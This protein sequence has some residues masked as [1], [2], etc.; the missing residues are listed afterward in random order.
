MMFNHKTVL[1]LAVAV[2]AALVPSAF[3]ADHDQGSV[4]NAG[5]I[6][7]INLDA[8]ELVAAL[9]GD[10]VT[11]SNAIFKGGSS[12]GATFTDS[13]TGESSVFG[14]REG[15][16]LSTGNV[17]NTMGP[18]NNDGE[19]GEKA[20]T[21]GDSDLDDEFFKGVNE[22]RDATVLEFD[23]VC[24]DPIGFS[25]QYVFGS[26]EYNEFVGS[27]FNDV[28]AVFLNGKNIALLPDNRTVSINNINCG[29]YDIDPERNTFDTKR[30][31]N[32]CQELFVDNTDGAGLKK[33]DTQFDGF[34][35]AIYTNQ[36]PESGVNRLK[37]VVAD[38]R[39]FAIDSAVLLRRN[40]LV[41][42]PPPAP[43]GNGGA[44]GDPHF[45]T[46]RG[47]HYDYHGECDLV[48]IHNAEFESGLGLDVHIRTKLRRDMSYISS[49][50]LRI[51][52]DVL[53][54]ASQGVYWFN[55][56][57]KADL[58]DEFAGFA[59]LHTHPTDKQHLF[60]VYLGDREHIKIK[61]YQDF[62]SVLIEQ[63]NSGHFLHSVGLMG[64]FR[65]GHMIARDGTTV[66]DDANAFG[67]EWQVLNTEPSLFQTVRFP[68]H[69]NGC[70][71]PTPVQANLLRRRLAETSSV[72]ELAAEK[73]CANWGEGKSD[74]VFDVLATGDLE[75]A[76]VGAY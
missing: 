66:I 4:A 47:Q 64:D 10:G 34:T 16:V 51:G 48:L 33:A 31:D 53:E 67:Q 19:Q 72:D 8:K 37:I 50:S 73:A 15:I 39:D 7:T 25:F 36:I 3:G 61:T 12:T 62:V 68:Q 43:E 20:G 63:G 58:P 76:V 1:G 21:D 24:D 26:E 74:C 57:L 60:D 54:V 13:S 17:R 70:T 6:V 52:K 46:W 27:P 14:F 40:S 2:A 29:K 42:A 22:T 45:R 18:P 35:K 56:A 32:Y 65:M 55:N 75:M 59:F 28:F 5:I 69:P 38:T 71:M 44:Q 49:V 23:F 11:T 9:T 41:C 30:K